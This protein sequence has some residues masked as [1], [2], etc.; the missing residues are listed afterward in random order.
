MADAQR[1]VF[2]IGAHQDDWQL[3]MSPQAYND[4][5]DG[6]TTVIFMYTTAGDAGEDPG[7]RRGRSA[8]A[9][10][11]IQFAR[12]LPLAAARPHPVQVQGHTIACYTI[13]NTRSYYL[14]LPDGNGDGGGFAA[15]G[16]QS[17]ERLHAGSIAAIDA[18]V[19][20]PEYA[21][22]YHSWQDLVATMR[23]LLVAEAGD[24]PGERMVHILDP[25]GSRHTDHRLTGMAVQEA[26]AGDARFRLAMYE[27]Y[28]IP[29]KEANV[30]GKDLILKSGLYLFYA[31]TA[32]EY[33][34]VTQHL[35]DWHLSFIPRQY[36]TE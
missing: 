18:L 30:H 16:H 14:D 20:E 19:D 24:G 1:V 11:S 2:Y 23:A 3:F 25:R 10:S 9:I 21:A 15:T 36:R 5:V 31:Q 22:S 28:I 26:I 17:I 12:R 13:A 4:L 8:G 34:G 27:E 32:F 7:W 35:D 33:S 6:D 29:D